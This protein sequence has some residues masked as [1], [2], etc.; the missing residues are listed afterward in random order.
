MS[1]T[2]VARPDARATQ[3][4]GLRR[5]T[6]GV[7]ISGSN[8]MVKGVVTRPPP[9]SQ[10]SASSRVGSLGRVAYPMPTRL[11]VMDIA[12]SMNRV[13]PLPKPWM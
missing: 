11:W 3:S 5:G 13:P 10:P 7:D 4:T 9:A 6:L 1:R 2:I 12:E 8:F